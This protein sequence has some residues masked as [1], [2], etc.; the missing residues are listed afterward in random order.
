MA[1]TGVVG[2]CGAAAAGLEGY[3]RATR[4]MD[5]A[6]EAIASGRAGLGDPQPLVDV[7]TAEHQARASLA[8]VAAAHRMQ[9]SLLDILA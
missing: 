5:V 8:V 2:G 3:R 9:D 6:A 4:R 1:M 7:K